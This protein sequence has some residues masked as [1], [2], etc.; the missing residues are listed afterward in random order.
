MNMKVLFDNSGNPHPRAYIEKR[1]GKFGRS[2][3]LTVQEI[4]GTT[5]DRI[6]K[7]VF[8]R[9]TAKLREKQ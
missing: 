2:Y 4:I 6:D 7:G 3:S 9:N 5:Q 8:L 1:L